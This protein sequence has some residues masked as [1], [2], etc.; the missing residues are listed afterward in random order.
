M[1]N[2]F[3]RSETEQVKRYSSLAHL[4]VKNMPAR[5]RQVASK[6]LPPHLRAWLRQFMPYGLASIFLAT[7]A[8]TAVTL[9]GSIPKSV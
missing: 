9:C 3:L 8:G 6:N 4:G 1:T 5:A 2:T 7:L